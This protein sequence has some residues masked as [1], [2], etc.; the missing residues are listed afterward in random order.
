MAKR[1]YGQFCGLARAVELLG[2]RWALLVVRDLLVSPKRFTDLR[3]GLPR[4]PTN[5]LSDRLRELEDAGVVHRK[6]LPRPAGSIV[7]E[8]TEYGAQLDDIVMRLGRWGAQRL[9][10]PGPDEI[11]TVDSLIM[12]LR[13][14]F[15]PE[16]AIGPEVNYELRLGE[17]VIHV[18]IAD[19][20]RLE[21]AAGSLPE[22]DLVI[23]TGPA[24]KTLMSGEL[25]PAEAIANDSV[26]LTGNP[27]LL[28]RFVETF[29][30]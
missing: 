5:V 17:I 29:R 16:A 22:A 10:E 20:H 23:E 2:E 18:R 1:A 28:T 30:I 12:A 21:V 6:V 14:T 9:G 15:R 27:A 19:D 25:S 3:R 26:A 13:S 7:Y 11:I 8:L 24:I 4:I